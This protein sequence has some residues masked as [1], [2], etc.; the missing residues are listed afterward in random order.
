MY[1]YIPCILH[2]LDI[3]QNNATP[4]LRG[5][6]HPAVDMKAQYEIL[7]PKPFFLRKESPSF[8]FKTFPL[9]GTHASSLL[10]R[11]P[12]ELSKRT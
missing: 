1:L 10:Y 6:Q 2:W 5:C 11:H 4:F 7:Q 8:A 9:A 12:R 3:K